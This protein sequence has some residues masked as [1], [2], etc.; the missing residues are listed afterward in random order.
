MPY[1]ETIITPQHTHIAI[2][3][4]TEQLDAL[5]AMWGDAPLPAHYHTAQALKR[6]R[7]IVATA[8]LMRQHF[9]QDIELRHAPNGA[10]IIDNG[11]ISI[12]HTSTHIAI[13]T[14]AT[15]QVG[16]DIETLGERAPRVAPRVLSQSE[17][18]KLP[19]NDST[20]CISI[21]D[22]NAAIHIAWSVKEA[23]YKIHPTAVEF[24]RDIILTQPITLPTGTITA[25]VSDS[26]TPITAHYTLYNDCSLAWAVI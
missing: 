19:G 3:R 9:G 7:E 20:Q 2:W 5:L 17:I 13:A 12:S 8:L 23:I 22:R 21:S 15:A 10:P 18:E 25:L 6:K 24:R 1:C 26:T 14:H 16:V 11:Y 4:L